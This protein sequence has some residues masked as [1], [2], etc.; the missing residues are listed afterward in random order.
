Y[1]VRVRSLDTGA[2]GTF[3]VCQVDFTQ[4]PPTKYY[5]ENDEWFNGKVFKQ[6]LSAQSTTEE[7]SANTTETNPDWNSGGFNDEPAG[8]TSANENAETTQNAASDEEYNGNII[9]EG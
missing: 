6:L 3:F 8:T 7:T 5:G 1:A 4:D 2:E 9:A